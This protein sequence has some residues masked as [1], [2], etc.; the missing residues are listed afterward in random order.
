MIQKKPPKN[1]TFAIKLVQKVFKRKTEYEKNSPNFFCFN[2]KTFSCSVSFS[3]KKN[4][5]INIDICLIH[6]CQCVLLKHFLTSAIEL[7]KTIFVNLKSGF[8]FTD[9]SVYL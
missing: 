2:K 1:L 5:D 4:P 8:F 9:K 3:N 7:C 6:H